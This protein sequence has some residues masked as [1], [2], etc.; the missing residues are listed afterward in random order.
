MTYLK[1]NFYMMVSN[2]KLDKSCNSTKSPAQPQ[3]ANISWDFVIMGFVIPGFHYS[4]ALR[5]NA[6]NHKYGKVSPPEGLDERS[7]VQANSKLSVVLR[8]EVFGRTAN[9]H[10]FGNHK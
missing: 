9:L 10:S 1:V 7:T 4:S 3:V 5:K 2:Y 8:T 6:S